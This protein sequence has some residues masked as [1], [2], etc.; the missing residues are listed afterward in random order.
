MGPHLARSCHVVGLQRVLV[1]RIAAPAADAQILRR[2]QKRRGYGQ[3]VHLGPQTIDDLLGADFAF[4]QR[5][6]R[7]VDKSAIMP[8][9]LP[10]V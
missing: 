1:E 9:P 4:I 10:P 8:P 6:E 5:L 7:G 2:L 3:A